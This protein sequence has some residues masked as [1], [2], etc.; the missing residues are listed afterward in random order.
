MSTSDTNRD[1]ARILLSIQLPLVMDTTFYASDS[2]SLRDIV[3]KIPILGFYSGFYYGTRFKFSY[4]MFTKDGSVGGRE[5]DPYVIRYRYW[6]TDHVSL[7]IC[8]CVRVWVEE[9]SLSPYDLFL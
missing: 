1:P 8:V 2:F 4:R 5:R 3:L 6:D 9:Y 7:C